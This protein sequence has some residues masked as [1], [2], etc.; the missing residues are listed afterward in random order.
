MESSNQANLAFLL[1]EAISKYYPIG[2]P[3]YRDRYIGYSKLEQIVEEKI[4]TLIDGHSG[5]KDWNLFKHAIHNDFPQFELLDLS[6]YQEPSLKMALKFYS[7]SNNR[8]YQDS[9]INISVSLMSSYFTVF[10][11]ESFTSEADYRYTVNEAPLVNNYGKKSFGPF[12][13]ENISELEHKWTSKIIKDI[14]YYY[15]NYSFVD[16]RFLQKSITGV[17][18]FGTGL[19]TVLEPIKFSFYDILFGD[20]IF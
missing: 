15:P 2:L 20:N 4:N 10:I 8:I 3:F 7:S 1:L 16:Y 14:T 12:H 5:P 6:Y 18:P 13:R 17:I 19:D 9:Y 11:T